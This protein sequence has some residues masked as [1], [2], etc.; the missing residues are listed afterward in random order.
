MLLLKPWFLVLIVAAA[1]ERLTGL[2]SGVAFE[3]DW[4]VLVMS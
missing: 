1:I 2:A 3:R 4:V